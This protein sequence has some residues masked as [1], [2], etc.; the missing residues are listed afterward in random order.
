[1]SQGNSPLALL[2]IWLWTVLVANLMHRYGYLTVSMKVL[3]D[4]YQ[5]HSSIPYKNWNLRT[6]RV[7]TAPN[8]FLDIHYTRFDR[9][10][11]G[12]NRSIQGLRN[13]F[14]F[15]RFILYKIWQIQTRF[16]KIHTGWKVHFIRFYRYIPYTVWETLTQL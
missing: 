6:I 8:R 3:I 16:K 9:Y 12:F 4:L 2:L 15:D 10:I 14:R 5:L 1:M 11:Q 7:L 13:L